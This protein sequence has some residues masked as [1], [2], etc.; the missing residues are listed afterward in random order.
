MS[1]MPPKLTVIIQVNYRAQSISCGCIQMLRY[2]TRLLNPT[3]THFKMTGA[4]KPLLPTYF[5]HPTI[6]K[7]IKVFVPGPIL[8]Y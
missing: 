2:D 8:G 3:Y 4:I 6:Q 5:R 7:A 1:V